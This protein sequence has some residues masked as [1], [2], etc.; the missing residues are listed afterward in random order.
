MS[1]H[2]PCELW[3]TPVLA[4]ALNRADRMATGFGASSCERFGFSQ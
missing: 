2:L 3:R 4:V 1:S